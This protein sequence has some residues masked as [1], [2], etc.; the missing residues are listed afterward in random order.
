MFLGFFCRLSHK[1]VIENGNSFVSIV[2]SLVY[3][4]K[5]H[6]QETPNEN[7]KKIKKEKKLENGKE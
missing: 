5:E 6:E 1:K 2:K 7:E 4:S 3:G